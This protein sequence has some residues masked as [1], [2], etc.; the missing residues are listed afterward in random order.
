[1]INKLLRKA[2]RCIKP[3]LLLTIL[4]STTAYAGR[5]PAPEFPE[6]L[7][8][9]NVSRPLTLSDLQGRV[10]IL[11]FWTYGCVNCIHVVEELRQLEH[12][13]GDALVVIGVHSPKFPNERRL[14][15]LRRILQRY[16]RQHPII[17]D[18]EQ[19][20]MQLYGV[21]A[22]PTLMVI[23]TDGLVVG[24]VAGE[25]HTER[26]ARLIE[27]L[28]K[29]ADNSEPAPALPL[30][31][32]AARIATQPLASP[33]KI[34]H[35]EGDL[36]ISDT[37]HHRIIIAGIKEKQFLII[38]GGSGG[39]KDGALKSARF[40]YPQ[41]VIK[42]ENNLFVADTGNHAVR[43]IDLTTGQ[44]TTLAGTGK[45]GYDLNSASNAK[46]IKLRSPWDL[47]LRD[48]SLYI[49]MA[50]SHQIWRLE[51][52]TGEIGPYAG[53]GGEGL[54]NGKLKEA[55]FSQPSG[56]AL[57][58]NRLFVTDAEASAIREINLDTEIVTT[59]V[60]RG[61]FDYG[62]IDG[63]AGSA[64]LQHPVGISVLDEDHLLIADTYN[65]KIKSYQL[66]S[67]R[68]TTLIGSGLPGR[69]EETLGDS[70]NE[71]GGVAAAGDSIWIA[72]T[73]NDRI[74]RYERSSNRLIPWDIPVE[75]L[76]AGSPPGKGQ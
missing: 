48:R 21:R 17:Q 37:L 56:L 3:L 38:G 75:K 1:M 59:L 63:V 29:E 4:L 10:T 62:D 73:N 74:I 76:D 72:D 71:P 42:Y 45:V 51:L 53:S 43:H 12:Q 52:D 41:G 46:T 66:S 27:K 5:I 49:A 2:N 69:G 23:D 20:L 25:G 19:S 61:L 14:D 68:V 65:H 39:F 6:N 30:Q 54:R 24:Y 47:A 26:L 32:D 34:I 22:W 33:G 18:S 7:P 9:L 50:G 64:K 13:F 40:S 67:G 35:S 58:G 31:S 60:G 11:D 15:T 44:V 70:L 16:N 36:I 57:L 8:W 55:T 28:L